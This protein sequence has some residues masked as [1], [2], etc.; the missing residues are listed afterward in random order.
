[1]T[2]SI[3]APAH[4]HTTRVDVYPA[5]FSHGAGIGESIP[6]HFNSHFTVANDQAKLFLKFASKQL[7]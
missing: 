3:T 6:S 7:Y 1:M 4:L 5:L 2:F